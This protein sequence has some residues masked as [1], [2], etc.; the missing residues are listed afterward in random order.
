MKALLHKRVK[1]EMEIYGQ[2]KLT[3]MVIHVYKGGVSVTVYAMLH[4]KT[5]T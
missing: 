5:Q 1:E 4:I 2:K 3:A